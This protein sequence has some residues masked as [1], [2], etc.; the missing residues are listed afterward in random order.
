MILLTLSFAVAFAVRAST[1]DGALTMTVRGA[2]QRSGEV[3]YDVELYDHFRNATAARFAMHGPIGVPL[4]AGET[5]NGVPF[6]VQLDSGEDTLG[7]V[8]RVRDET[9]LKA[10]WNLRGHPPLID[11]ARAWQVGGDVHAPHLLTRIL[12]GYTAEARKARVGGIIIV[13]MLIDKEGIV[14]E[15]SIV[16]PLPFGL[17]ESALDAVMNARFQPAMRRGQPVDA[18][19][20]ITV[21]FK[22]PL[23]PG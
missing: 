18:I 11:P 23:P 1:S 2:P 16:K 9:M 13:E 17:D 5:R 15:A 20:R 21:N 19:F 10:R 14:R 12:P 22:V 4:V 8:L 3:A 6:H 7:A